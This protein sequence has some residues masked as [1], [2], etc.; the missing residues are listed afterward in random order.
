VRT[1]VRAEYLIDLLRLCFPVLWQ[2]LALARFPISKPRQ[3]QH[4]EHKVL[5]SGGKRERT[6]E[7]KRRAGREQR[8]EA[9]GSRGWIWQK[10]MAES[11]SSECSTL[12]LRTSHSLTVQSVEADSSLRPLRDQLM[13]AHRHPRVGRRRDQRE[14]RQQERGKAT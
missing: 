3:V 7:A 4:R 11:R 12:P 2:N 1:C 13:R 8:N 5:V 9:H 10:R 6:G 14:Q